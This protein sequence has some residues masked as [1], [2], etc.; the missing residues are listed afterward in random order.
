ME[1]GLHSRVIQE[2]ADGQSCELGAVGFSCGVWCGTWGGR[3]MQVGKLS[4]CS[5]VEALPQDTLIEVLPEH[6]AGP[7]GFLP[8]FVSR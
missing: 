6:Q 3:S 1:D 4:R 8:D 2:T 7:T 5:S